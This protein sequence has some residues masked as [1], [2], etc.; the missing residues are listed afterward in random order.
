MDQKFEM[1]AA[2]SAT[3]QTQEVQREGRVITEVSK[4]FTEKQEILRSLGLSGNSSSVDKAQIDTSERKANVNQIQLRPW[5][6]VA[7][8]TGRLI[9][10]FEDRVVLE[11]LMDREL[12]M[13]QERTFQKILFKGY[14]LVVGSI[15]YL[16]IFERDNEMRIEV[17]E[18]VRRDFSRDFEKKDLEQLIKG[19]KLFKVGK[20]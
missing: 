14:E 20:G 4:P 11:C 9:D 8:I 7:N 15:F 13:Y 6:N 18:D 10:S 1:E 16:R 17:H 12:K 5:R 19:S 2:I 3:N